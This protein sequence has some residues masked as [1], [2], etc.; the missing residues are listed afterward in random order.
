MAVRLPQ[1]AVLRS[2]EQLFRQGPVAGLDEG[3][4]LER[5][6]TYR[7]AAILCDLEG[8]SYAEAARRLRCPLGTVQSRLARGRA[9][10]RARLLRRGL[11]PLAITATLTETA[12]AA[13]PESWAEATVR[14]AVAL[15]A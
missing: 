8:R 10:L 2:I 11:A 7:D 4:L 15:A 13:V 1:V 5:F 14:A 12:P 6:A 9:R 3:Q